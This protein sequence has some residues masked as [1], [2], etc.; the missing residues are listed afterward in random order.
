MIEAALTLVPESR[1]A[2]RARLL[3]ALALELNFERDHRHR[4]ALVD[5]ALA[6]ARRSG[7][8]RA[9]AHVLHHSCLSIQRP[10]TIAER[11]AMVDEL[12]VLA[13]R[14]ADPELRF[15]SQWLPTHAGEAGDFA[16]VDRSIAAAR[17][18]ADEIGQP[19]LLW[20]CLF[21]ESCRL[22]VAARLDEAEAI[23]A[24]AGQMSEP[25]AGML[26][27]G[28]RIG[29][30]WEQGRSEEIVDL[31]LQAGADNPGISGFRPAAAVVL[32]EAGRHQDARALLDAAAREGFDTV[33]HDNVWTTTLA[34]WAEVVHALGAAEHARPLY[35]ELAPWDHMMVWN[36]AVAYNSVDHYL[37]GLAATLGEHDRAERH[38][39]RA[40]ATAERIPA[41]LWLARTLLWYG[42]EL[43]A[44]GDATRARELLRRAAAVAREHGAARV[45]REASALAAAGAPR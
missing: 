31:V 8:D 25:D 13:D 33:P 30:L 38:F 17:A 43:N 37:G 1:P 23:A 28:Q 36:T 27:A 7:D 20:T 2:L 4:R 39:E 42:Q 41:P 29:L 26:V 32:A 35:D 44:A 3:S 18:I 22:R 14:F 6:L 24:Q 15:W 9:L 11:Q 19:A 45:E 10:E 34:L 21:S 12:R 5:E 16:E 40:I